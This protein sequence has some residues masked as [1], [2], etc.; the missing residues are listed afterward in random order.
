MPSPHVLKTPSAFERPV[1]TH[2]CL[3]RQAFVAAV[4]G[5]QNLQQVGDCL[6]KSIGSPSVLHGTS[7]WRGCQVL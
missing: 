2:V 5:H 3:K 4:I 6:N 7:C 1:S